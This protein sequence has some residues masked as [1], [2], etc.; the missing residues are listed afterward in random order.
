MPKILSFGGGVQST[1]LAILIAQGKIEC[2]AIVFCDTGFE[3]S[4]VFDFLKQHTLKI[5]EAAKIPFFIAKAEDFSGMLNGESTFGNFLLPPFF[6]GDGKDQDAI[7]RQPAYCSSK[8]KGDTFKRFLAKQF[9]E[10]SYEVMMGFSTDE[11]HRAGRMK[12]SKKYQYKFPLL[13]LRMNRG[14]CVALVERTFNAPPPRSSCYF[15][16]NH[17]QHEWREV[18][19][20][21]DR[22][23]VIE[24]DEKI[25]GSLKD[26]MQGGIN[27]F[28]TV[29]CKPIEECDF[30]DKNEVI[31]SRLCAG[32]CF[33]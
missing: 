20:S 5:L 12:S 27:A 11:M 26:K 4:I 18:M 23:K 16:P 6:H 2:D 1:A 10:K 13:N 19:Q 14:D 28:L 30:D 7:S 17:T 3:Q 21:A 25:R 15:C 24:L 32:G 8:W 33:L 31:F 9:K 22:E 29:E